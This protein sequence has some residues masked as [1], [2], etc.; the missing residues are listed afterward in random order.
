MITELVKN[1]NNRKKEYMVDKKKEPMI[2]QSLAK[3]RFNLLF[4]LPMCCINNLLK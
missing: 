4:T 3:N 2:C 1:I